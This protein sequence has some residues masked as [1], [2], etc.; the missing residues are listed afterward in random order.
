MRDK[1]SVTV[2]GA[3][4]SRTSLR[5]QGR[6]VRNKDTKQVHKKYRLSG[7]VLPGR[8]LNGLDGIALKNWK[9]DQTRLMAVVLGGL[10]AR[11]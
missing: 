2:F 8:R 1:G 5:A 4:F 10:W 11:D 6:F 7:D 9:W 3:V